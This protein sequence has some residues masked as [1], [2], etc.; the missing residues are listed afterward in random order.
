KALTQRWPARG[1]FFRFALLSGVRRGQ[2]L[3]TRLAQFH[4]ETGSMTWRPEQTKT[5]DAHNVTYTGEALDLLRA[6]WEHRSLACPAFF[7]EDGSALTTDK[8]NAAWWAACREV[9]LPIGR[10]AGGYVIHELRHTMVSEWI[11][12]GQSEKSIMDMTGHKA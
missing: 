5:D 12:A 2:L 11:H 1:A 6:F 3:A 10:K 9:G 7:Q 8:L 4:I